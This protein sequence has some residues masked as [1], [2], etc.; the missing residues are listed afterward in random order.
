MTTEPAKA[1]TEPVKDWATDY[2]IFDAGY[3]KDPFPVWD[4]LREKCPVAHTERWGGSWMPTTYEDLRKIAA[5]VEIFSS[6]NPLVANDGEPTEEV[7][8]ELEEQFSVGAPPISSDPPIHTWSRA[9]L[10]PKFSIK[11]VA[12]Y[13]EETRELCRSL[14]DG[15]VDKGRA[16]AAADY[17]Q[18]IPSRVIASMLGIPQERA[19]DFTDWVRGFLE[20]G[21][22][23][24][25]LR[26]GAAMQILSFLNE[27]IQERQANPG[28]DLISYLL[29]A[30]TEGAPD[31]IPPTHVL[32]TCFLLLVA[33]IDTTWS[34]IGSAMWH[35]AQNPDDCKRLI[36]EPELIT[37]AVEELLRAY[38][39]VTMAR[40]VTRDAEYNG[41]P[42]QENDKI[43]MNFPAANRDP[44]K[45]DKPDEVILDREVNP[46]IAFGVGIHR[47]AGSNLARM[48]M[49]VAIEE[50]LKRIPEFRL[51]DPEAV[52]WAGGQ[53]RGP[54][55]C[56]VVF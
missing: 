32:G 28:D 31:P 40:E 41:C 6:R 43:L 11:E 14:I 42:M 27:Q 44:A 51:E 10:L 24:V 45:F 26:S 25:D 22:T 13:E 9:L 17:A 39:P 7:G 18:Q 50:W 52:T 56:A 19:G 54:R 38:S 21:L 23:N 12:R 4:E 1:R 36:D 34:S 8:A 30:K 29:E 2:D 46:H 53:V 16:D 47:C 35:L 48:E 55:K 5:N 3:V 49:K 15:F 33:G 20:Y 37:S